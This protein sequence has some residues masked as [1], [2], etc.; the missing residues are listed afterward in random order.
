MRNEKAQALIV[1]YMIIASFLVM[2]AALVSKAI[3]ERQ[4]AQR[5]RQTQ[6][7]FYL[8]EGGVESAI[9]E[10]TQ[11]IADY[12]IDAAAETFSTSKTFSSFYDAAAIVTCTR[13]DDADSVLTENDINVLV[14]KYDIASAVTHPLNSSITATVHQIVARRLI[15]TFQHAVFYNDDLEALPGA[16]MTLSGRIHSNSDMYLGTHATLTIDSFSLHSAGNIYNRRKDSE[17]VMAGD[18]KIRVTKSGSAKYEEMDGLD[19]E[20]PDWTNESTDRWDGTVQS[21]VHGVQELSAPS[22]AS[23]QTDGYYADN[24]DVVIVNDEIEK[25][26]TPLV[27]GVNCPD[28]TIITTTTFYNNREDKYVKMTEVDL[29]KLAGYAPGDPD[30][31]PSFPNNLPSNG[32]LYATRDDVGSTQS[33]GIRLNNGARIYRDGGLTVVSDEPVYVKG[34]YN[35]SSEEPSSI[36]CDSINL[37]SGS[38]NDANSTSEYVSSRPASTTTVNSAFISG[39]D[40]TEVGGYNGGLEN[41]PRLHEAWG[42]KTL[43]IKGSFVELWESEKATGSWIYGD[44]QY[45]APTRNWQYDTAFN[46]TDN[47]PPFTP[48][49]VEA[50]RLAW[51]RE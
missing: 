51:W 34:N 43:N 44:P 28:D 11:A 41:Y 3:T 22:V 29:K 14:R 26:G 30:G 38:W 21:S 8:A 40:E 37:L 9:N 10:F 50:E 24:A 49:T 2:T 12:T 36:I 7:A 16:N 15:P 4:L 35:T 25:G 32:L 27:E 19:S 47:L 42:G 31:S 1:S 46:D 6:E 39:V 17:Q 48:W 13:M 5:A 45:T 20:D 18:V 23:I 33:P